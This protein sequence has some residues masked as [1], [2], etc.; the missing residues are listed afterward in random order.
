MGDVQPVATSGAGSWLQTGNSFLSSALDTWGKVEAIKAQRS[1]S[2]ND[3]TLRLTQTDYANGAAVQ[4][5]AMA[6][7]ESKDAEM[8]MYKKGLIVFGGLLAVGVLLKVSGY[9]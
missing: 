6:Q 7:P 1:S 2:G 3:Q 5:D 4:V 9:K 8:S